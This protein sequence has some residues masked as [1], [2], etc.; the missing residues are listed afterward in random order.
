MIDSKKF[1]IDLADVS[2]ADPFVQVTKD[3]LRVYRHKTDEFRIYPS[4]TT[5]LSAM[6]SERD[7]AGLAKWRNRVGHKEAQRVSTR[8]ANRGKKLHKLCEDYVTNEEIDLSAQP[9]SMGVL[10]EQIKPVLDENVDMIRCIESRLVSD[11]LRLAGSVDLIAEWQGEPA[12]IDFKTSTK[13]KKKEWIDNYFHQAALYSFMF[14]EM[15]GILPKKIVIAIANESFD[16]PTIYI[17][18]AKNYIEA[19]TDLVKEYHRTHTKGLDKVFYD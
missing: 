10:F 11:K 16:K 18:K 19:A 1:K 2:A 6:K 8:T 12:V 5:V 9:P 7:K 4:V 14:W 3:G 15:T 13:F 17:E